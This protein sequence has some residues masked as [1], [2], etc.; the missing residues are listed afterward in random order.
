MAESSDEQ[1][2]SQKQ[3]N[4]DQRLVSEIK[5]LATLIK[6]YPNLEFKFQCPR[7]KTCYTEQG[8]NANKTSYRF[9]SVQS[10][11]QF[12]STLLCSSCKS[13]YWG[14]SNWIALG[15]KLKK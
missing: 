11:I 5:I 2:C 7:C 3:E 4:E 14:V 9:K 10:F 12:S 1:K 15:L 8:G 6:V 13:K